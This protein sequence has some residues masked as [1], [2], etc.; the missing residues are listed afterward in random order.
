VVVAHCHV[1]QDPVTNPLG[2]DDDYFSE[3]ESEQRQ[4]RTANANYARVQRSR[5]RGFR[6]VWLQQY[7]WLCCNSDYQI[8]GAPVTGSVIAGE[9]ALLTC[10][11]CA[12][13]LLLAPHD[14]LGDGGGCTQRGLPYMSVTR[15]DLFRR[16]NEDPRHVRLWLRFNDSSLPPPAPT[17]AFKGVQFY[18]Q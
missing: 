9:D 11:A 14:S 8:V 4:G 6:A 15:P 7:R 1:L 5:E 12:T 17:V 3:P 13:N 16:H 2:L 10:K 18:Q